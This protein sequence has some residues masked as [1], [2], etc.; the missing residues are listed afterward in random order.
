M[1]RTRYATA[2]ALLLL[3]AGLASAQIGRPGFPKGPPGGGGFPGRPG[4]PGPGNP[5]IPTPPSPPPGMPGAP[6]F[7]GAPAEDEGGWQ[8]SNCKKIISKGMIK[9]QD[10]TCPFCGIRFGNTVGGMQADM[11]ERR[12][13]TDERM[14]QQR[15]EMDERMNRGRPSG[16]A[17]SPF[18]PTAGPGND[19]EDDGSGGLTGKSGKRGTKGLGALAWLILGIAVVLTVATFIGLG[20]FLYN[21]A[22]DT[23]PSGRERTRTRKR[24][25][26]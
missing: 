2:T 18:G 15:R 11:E 9:P 26:R 8:C 7:P 1:T 21:T 17:P 23:M 19:E 3:T 6:G 16:F 4:I 5:G 20:V 24:R 10:A 25:R 22:R 13:A 14:E 12:A